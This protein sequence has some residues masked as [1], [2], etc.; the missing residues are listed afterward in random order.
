MPTIDPTTKVNVIQKRKFTY[1]LW[2]A[3]S[4]VINGVTKS[5]APIQ[6]ADIQSK[7]SCTCHPLLIVIGNRSLKSKPK[8]TVK[9][10]KSWT[11]TIPA[12]TWKRKTNIA[13]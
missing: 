4:G 2:P 13:A 7:E 5:E 6:H 10:T 11:V 1:R 3:G 12:R 8:K 9:F